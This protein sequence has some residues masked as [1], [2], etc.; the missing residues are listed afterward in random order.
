[1]AD[2]GRTNVHYIH[3]LSYTARERLVG[4]FVLGALVILLAMVAVS[5]D[6]AQAFHQNV[7]YN[8][9]IENA[10]GITEDT[11]VFVAGFEAGAV[12]SFEVTDDA[13]V[14]VV[15]DV[16]EESAPA[17]R[18]DSEA[19]IEA[20]NPL[21]PPTIQVSQGTLAEPPLPAGANIPVVDRVDFSETMANLM[22][23]VRNLNNT[24]D[25]V[26]TLMA[27]VGPSDIGEITSSLATA[28]GNLAIMSDRIVA[29]EGSLGRV[30]FDDDFEAELVEAMSALT[31]TLQATRDRMRQL[32]TVFDSAEALTEQASEA[33]GGLPTLMSQ[34]T[35]LI[36]ELNQTMT[37]VNSE[38]EAF[39]DLVLRTRLLMDQMDETLVAIQNTWPISESMPEPEE[40]EL[41]ELAPPND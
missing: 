28:T 9:Y 40:E 15:I 41:V 10:T 19:W 4:V 1:M 33:L 37:A 14:K 26:N 22:A 2:G 17:V 11:R 23:A 8:L 36:E 3:N 29:G 13:R 35:T 7:Q 5:R 27:T 25:Q 21:Q 16:R 32:D 30:L 18:F 39:P 6:L 20:L 24:L 12:A 31:E 34:T 38:M